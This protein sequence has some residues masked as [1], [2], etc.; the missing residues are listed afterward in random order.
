MQ[1]FSQAEQCSC[2][3]HQ[4]SCGGVLLW[5]KGRQ[6]PPHLENIHVF[7]HVIKAEPNYLDW[8]RL[9]VDITLAY[10]VCVHAPFADRSHSRLKYNHYS[11]KPD[12]DILMY[13]SPHT[14]SILTTHQDTRLPYYEFKCVTTEILVSIRCSHRRTAQ[15]FFLIR[16]AFNCHLSR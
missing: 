13:A 2:W 3:G 4:T 10:T 9:S 14:G 12:K 16:K 5:C 1:L 15:L 7:L 11:R 6:K 8:M